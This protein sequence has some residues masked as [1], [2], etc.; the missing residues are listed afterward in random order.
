LASNV[1]AAKLQALVPVDRAARVLHPLGS[2]F[3]NQIAQRLGDGT[4]RLTSMTDNVSWNA[5]NFYRG[6]GAWNVDASVFKNFVWKERYRLRF[7]R[8]NVMNHP[9]DNNPDDHWIAESQHSRP[10]APR[11]ISSHFASRGRSRIR[12]SFS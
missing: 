5:R 8:T 6:P 7:R 10:S 1:D 2:N 9:L 4:V 3:N 12:T 11:I